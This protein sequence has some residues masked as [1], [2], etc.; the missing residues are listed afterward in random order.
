M[1]KIAIGVCYQRVPF[2]RVD[3][4]V[5]PVW[6]LVLWMI[7]HIGRNH[8]ADD[9][10]FPQVR[11]RPGR[12]HKFHRVR[13]AATGIVELIFALKLLQ[14]PCSHGEPIAAFRPCGLAGGAALANVLMMST[15]RGLKI[16]GRR[17][18]C[19]PGGECVCQ[20]R[21]DGGHKQST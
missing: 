17:R 12:L 11:H 10:R 16:R 21:S 18:E 1:E 6:F 4:V 15:A 3:G 2:L 5:H 7:A 8:M 20:L 9:A 14:F 19:E 13:L